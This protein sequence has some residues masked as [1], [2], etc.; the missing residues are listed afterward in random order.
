MRRSCIALSLM[1]LS[2]GGDPPDR[3][4][5]GDAGVPIPPGDGSTLQDGPPAIPPLDGALGTPCNGDP[6]L[7]DRAYDGIVFLGTHLSM[8][9][10]PAW[11]H[12]TQGRTLTEQL[13]SGGVRALELEV[14]DDGGALALC[15]GSCAEGSL[16]LATALRDIGTFLGD[17]PSDVLSIVIRSHVTPGRIA[18]AF[19]SQDLVR[20][21]HVQPA[22]AAWPTLRAMIDGRQRLV[23]FADS[24]TA[25]EDAGAS[26][27]SPPGDAAAD[28]GP[29]PAW[30]HSA[31]AWLR[32]TPASVG[33]DCITAG[34]GP[35]VVVNHYDPSGTADGGALAAAHDP[36]VVAARLTRCRDDLGRWPTFLFV[37]FAD[38]GDPNRGVQIANGLQ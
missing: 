20:W 2:C 10:G 11:L 14:H 3:R 21:A 1:V 24:V 9:S 36:T 6:A 35:L 31:S 37:D 12:P 19:A 18:D 34:S 27:A 30:L 28:A 13:A 4:S 33:Q 38:I 17:N 8:A 16:S 23:V 29:P 5:R 32:E 22:G 25:A 7:C 15:S 26:D